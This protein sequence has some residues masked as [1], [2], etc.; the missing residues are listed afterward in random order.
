M[1]N[2]FKIRKMAVEYC[3]SLTGLSDEI[4]E[5]VYNA[6]IKG[7]TDLLNEKVTE[8]CDFDNYKKNLETN[9]HG[10]KSNNKYSSSINNDPYPYSGCASSRTGHI[11]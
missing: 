2:L 5:I 7:A 8:R 4:K 3:E 1:E 9:L 11:C 10:K 6:Y